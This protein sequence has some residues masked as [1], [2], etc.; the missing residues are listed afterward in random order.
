MYHLLS[1][2]LCLAS[3]LSQIQVQSP[4]NSFFGKQ[5]QQSQSCGSGIIVSEDDD[6]LYIA[7]N[8]HVVADSE[9]LTVQFDDD[10][11]V[12]AEIRGTDPDDDLAVVRVK[13]A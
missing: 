8:N 4:N 3:L 6:Y 5:S 10:S 12:K 13:K 7:T 2:R 1:M 9:E 11:V